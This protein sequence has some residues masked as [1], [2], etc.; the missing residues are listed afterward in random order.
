MSKNLHLLP[1]Y[2][3]KS[4]KIQNQG[5]NATEKTQNPVFLYH[6]GLIMDPSQFQRS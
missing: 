1:K 5:Q 4:I 6:L 3:N 2:K